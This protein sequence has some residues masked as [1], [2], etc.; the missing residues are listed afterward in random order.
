MPTFTRKKKDFYCL[1][2]NKKDAGA[3]FDITWKT[4]IFFGLLL[5]SPL[6]CFFPL[7]LL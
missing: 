6:Q 2:K 3:W 1:K 7:K 5:P 4:A